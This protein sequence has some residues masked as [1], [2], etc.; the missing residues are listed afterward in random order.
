MSLLTG[1]M[2]A[3][4]IAVIGAVML[5]VAIHRTS[6]KHPCMIAIPDSNNRS[7]VTWVP[8]KFKIRERNDHL[9]VRFRKHH[10]KLYAPPNQFMSRW[11]KTGT[12]LPARD[13]WYKLNH[14][15]ARDHIL[16]GAHFYQIND[17]EYKIML[18]DASGDFTVVDHDSRQLVRDGIR[19]RQKLLTS[20]KERALQVAFFLG[21]MLIIGLVAIGIWVLTLKAAQEQAITIL[22]AAQNAANALQ[23]PVGG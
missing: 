2:I 14:T 6:Y 19:D 12:E 15:N 7:S 5:A 9:E 22:N 13:D 17:D 23:P 11:L 21:A 16:R 20:F 1:L 4:P 10:G 18:V 3:G 8:D